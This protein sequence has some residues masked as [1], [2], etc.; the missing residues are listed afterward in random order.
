METSSNS[1]T[2]VHKNFKYP[3]CPNVST[4][5]WQWVFREPLPFRWTTLRGKHCRHPIVIM[6]VVDTFGLCHEIDLVLNSRILVWF[7]KLIAQPLT[8]EILALLYNC[9]KLHRC[10]P[11][12]FITWSIWIITLAD[13]WATANIQDAL[14]RM[15]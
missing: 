7:L 5:I 13:R 9:L 4:T 2:L 12:L 6:W 11:L 15:F 3:L 10:M 14:I 1:S 8:P